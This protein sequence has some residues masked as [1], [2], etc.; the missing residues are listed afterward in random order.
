M[1]AYRIEVQTAK[2]KKRNSFVC[3]ASDKAEA[4]KIASGV[5]LADGETISMCEECHPA[6]VFEAS[7]W[8]FAALF[9]THTHARYMQEHGDGTPDSIEVHFPHWHS[10]VKTGRKYINVDLAGSGVYMVTK[11]EGDIFSI[12]GYGVIHRGHHF[13]TLDTVAGW[14]WGD[15]RAQKYKEPKEHTPAFVFEGEAEPT[16]PATTSESAIKNSARGKV[17]ISEDVAEVLQSAEVDG[18]ELRLTQELDRPLYLAV[19]KVL[20]ALGGKWDR[21]KRVHIFPKPVADVLAEA[22]DTG[23]AIDKRK[24]LNQ[25]FTPPEIAARMVELA[26]IQDGDCIQEPSAGSGNIIREIFK[27]IPEQNQ[28]LVLAIEIDGDLV[29]QLRDSF[30]GL[31]VW[32]RDVL[33][34][35][36]LPPCERIIMNPPFENGVDIKHIEH[37]R[38]FLRPG[39]KLVALCANGPKQQA[40]FK[41]IADH[42]EELPASSFKSEGTN[43]NVALFTLLA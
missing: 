42:W 24:A 6:S 2:G 43:V 25:F 35:T 5:Y 4:D 31:N 9:Q 10:R 26:D 21:G 19:N 1:Q 32:Q 40:A 27:V 38:M 20:A 8:S 36:N 22:L 12:K 28:G 3:F 18:N 17:G 16:T 15:Y 41:G 37:M 33:E 30:Y 11:E 13:G 7:V 29:S 39:G 23:H 14:F 34:I